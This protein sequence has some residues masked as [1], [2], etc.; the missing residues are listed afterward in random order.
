[1]NQKK[2]NNNNNNNKLD[3]EKNNLEKAKNY[4]CN[5]FFDFKMIGRTNLISHIMKIVEQIGEN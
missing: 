1:M 5:P 2:K 3:A 4:L